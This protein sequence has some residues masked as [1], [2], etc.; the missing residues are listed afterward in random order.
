MNHKRQKNTAADILA[1]AD[2][3]QVAYT[4]TETDVW[5]RAITRLAGDDVDLDEIELLLIALQRAGC[6]S[7]PEALKLQINYLRE[8]KL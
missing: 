4:E 5:A 8:A 6:L 3:H 2:Q 7:R 1:L